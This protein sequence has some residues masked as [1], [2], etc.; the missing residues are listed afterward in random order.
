MTEQHP[1]DEHATAEHAS[2]E[3]ATAEHAADAAGGGRG[4][5]RR[6]FF[7]SAAGG[8][9]LGAL[10][11]V[12]GTLA[13]AHAAD[14]TPGDADAVG[15]ARAYPFY[16]GAHQVGIRTEPQRY[17]IYMTFD[18]VDGTTQL[19]LQTLLARWSAAIAQLMQGKSIGA[20]QPAR[21][22]AVAA[23][24]GEA[25]DLG[26]NALT[27]TLGFGP[28][29]FDDR[30]GLANRRPALLTPLPTLPSDQ[31]KPELSGGDLSLQA[32]ADDPQVAYHAIRDLARMGRGTVNTRWTVMGFGRASA[33]PHQSTPRNL[34]GFK[35]GT[36][37]ITSDDEYERFVWLNDAGWM[38]GGTYQVVRK[39]QMNI[40]IWDADPI[41]D[42]QQIFGRT[43]SEGAPLSGSREKDTPDFSAMRHGEPVMPQRSHVA[44]AAHENN[45]GIK[46][47][48]RSYNYTDGI[49]Q[50]GQLDAGLLFIA[51]MR[52]P[53]HFVALQRRL[54]A[55]DRLNE[56]IA[57]IGSALFAVPPAPRPGHYIGERLF[58]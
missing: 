45:D 38:S 11:G 54:G 17:C 25:A 5:S 57:H 19:E 27:V 14:A 24:T 13:A 2:A 33:G 23:D 41:G 49:S 29:V 30:F 10:G 9:A 20:V 58:A 39:I 4:L 37:N 34:L 28:G 44:L 8:V 7:A 18:L 16:G 1:P 26:P 53:Q 50:V 3:H 21:A 6:G 55:S 52:D 46:I 31:L 42:Q 48:R 32:C 56:Y 12:A 15:E 22:G 35:D 51:Y 36:R 47:L 40:E 43:K